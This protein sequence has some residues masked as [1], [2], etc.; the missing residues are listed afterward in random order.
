MAGVS[1]GGEML[2]DV[3]MKLGMSSLR[4]TALFLYAPLRGL[5]LPMRWNAEHAGAMT[6]LGGAAANGQHAVKEDDEEEAWRR[7]LR[8]EYSD[9]EG[10]G[11][12]GDD[13]GGNGA[14]HQAVTSGQT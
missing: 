14:L 2:E 10:G 7:R 12:G 4:G 1:F 5:P 3:Y 11:G 8:E 9:G 13:W 6:G